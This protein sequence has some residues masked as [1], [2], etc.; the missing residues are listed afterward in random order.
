MKIYPEGWLTVKINACEFTQQVKMFTDVF[1]LV[2]IEQD[3]DWPLEQS[4]TEWLKRQLYNRKI[5]HV[6]QLFIG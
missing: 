2:I 3:F 4:L 1:S 5:L 6:I